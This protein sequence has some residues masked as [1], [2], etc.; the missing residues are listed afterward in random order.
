MIKV[1]PE[2]TAFVTSE[3]YEKLIVQFKIS[4]SRLLLVL[5]AT[6][7]EATLDS[8]ERHSKM[9]YAFEMHFRIRFIAFSPCHSNGQTR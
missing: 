5:P 2:F 3:S 1:V 9:R 7:C 6:S 8:A 4:H